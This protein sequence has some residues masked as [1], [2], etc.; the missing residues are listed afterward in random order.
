MYYCSYFVTEDRV[1]VSKHEAQIR[2]ILTIIRNKLYFDLIK[3]D[4]RDE[5][6][7]LKYLWN[8]FSSVKWR[9]FVFAV[10]FLFVKLYFLKTHYISSVRVI[11]I[12]TVHTESSVDGGWKIY[13]FFNKGFWILDSL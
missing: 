4:T 2:N 12:T 9:F 8:P 1:I 13:K 3:G 6:V 11:Q 5:L 10:L 7:V